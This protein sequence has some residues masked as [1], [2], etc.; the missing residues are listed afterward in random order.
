[1]NSSSIIRQ[2]DKTNAIEIENGSHVVLISYA[3][4]VA[5]LVKSPDFLSRIA[6]VTDVKWSNTTSR[7][8]NAALARW[9][10]GETVRVS[11]SKIEK[12]AANLH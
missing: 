7:H 3:T 6:Y 4:P 12:L 10:A 11:Q 8:V 5:V 1:M 9:N 2:V